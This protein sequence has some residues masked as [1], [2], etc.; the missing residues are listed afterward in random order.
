MH[1][2]NCLMGDQL[3]R[4]LFCRQ[5]SLT[6]RSCASWWRPGWTCSCAVPCRRPQADQER[7]QAVLSGA[8]AW[9]VRYPDPGRREKA[10]PPTCRPAAARRPRHRATRDHR[11][12]AERGF[13]ALR[14]EIGAEIVVG[15]H[16]LAVGLQQ[17]ALLIQGRQPLPRRQVP[18]LDGAI[19]AGKAFHFVLLQEQGPGVEQH[20]RELDQELARRQRLAGGRLLRQRTLAQQ[21]DQVSAVEAPGAAARRQT[22]SR[23]RVRPGPGQS[24]CTAPTARKPC[25]PRRIRAGPRPLR[26]GR[27]GMSNS[28]RA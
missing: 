27:I 24:A 11:A 7:L 16:H 26:S 18:A 8:G 20:K 15:K 3:S 28:S 13:K 14:Q 5:P 25:R 6:W 17:Q 4:L 2:L 21:A 10:G 23:H 1:L 19:V 9:S 12:S 22:H